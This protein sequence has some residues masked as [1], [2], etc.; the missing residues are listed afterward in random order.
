MANTPYSQE[1]PLGAPSLS[2]NNITVDLMLKEP[3][4]I[5]AYLSDMAL[6]RYFAERIFPNQGGVSG[7]ALVYHQLTKNDLFPE[8]R[9]Q[10]VAPGA[11]FPEVTFDRP[12]PRTKQVEKRGGKFRVT[13]EARDRNDLS[14]IQTEGAK[15]ANDIVDQLHQQALAELEASIAEIG[16]D[17]VLDASEFS[18]AEAAELTVM[19]QAPSLQPA[20]V[21]V[22]LQKKAEVFELGGQYNLLILNPADEANLKLVYGPQWAS[23]LQSYGFSTV[24]TNRVSA[25]T[26]YAVQEG[27]VGQTRYE[28]PL[29]TV[30]W[31]DDS[32]ESHWVQA[33]VRNVYAVTHP[34]NAI[35]ITGLNA[36]D[37]S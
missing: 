17:L 28:Q 5:N 12:E 10:K 1:F 20:K 32:T 21:L 4:R 29:R 31:R 30:T 19:N 15:L 26:G 24:V 34:Y 33:S 14:L 2:G 11:E 3:T 9:A 18:W 36:Q 6:R 27:M 7:G 16:E 22:E 37:G 25:G 13:D 8:R 35:K 23:F